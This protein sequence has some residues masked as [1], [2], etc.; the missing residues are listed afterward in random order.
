METFGFM[1]DQKGIKPTNEF[2]D[3]IRNFE[4]PTSIKL[5]RGFFGLV[6]QAGYCSTQESRECL[7]KFRDALSVKK[8]VQ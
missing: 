6:N 2:I 1:I 3:H 8:T 4:R 7:A 5:V